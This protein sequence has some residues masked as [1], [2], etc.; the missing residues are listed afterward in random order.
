MI[1]L[2]ATEEELQALAGLIDAGVRAT[3]LRSVRDAVIWI[4]KIEAATKA[5]KE[6]NE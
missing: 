6:T 3:G 4:E 1:K 5:S 2:K